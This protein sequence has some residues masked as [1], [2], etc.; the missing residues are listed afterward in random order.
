M[1]GGPILGSI[2][3]TGGETDLVLEVSVANVSQK[4]GTNSRSL[5]NGSD[6]CELVR[7]SHIESSSVWTVDGR[8][9]CECI[10][11]VLFTM[12]CTHCIG[13]ELKPDLYYGS[14]LFYH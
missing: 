10:V 7:A 8:V 2:R 9:D 1:R 11:N 14:V 6:I 3:L 13:R 5:S 12:F 4:R